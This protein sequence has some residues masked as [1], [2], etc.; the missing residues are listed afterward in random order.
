MNIDQAFKMLC[1]SNAGIVLTCKYW[2]RIESHTFE[3]NHFNESSSPIGFKHR[4]KC[5]K[6]DFKDISTHYSG[7]KSDCKFVFSAA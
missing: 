5:I 4:I 2:E 6:Q 1:T 7:S 3:A